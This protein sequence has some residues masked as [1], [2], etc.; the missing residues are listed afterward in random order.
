MKA[1]KSA[2]AA[3]DA[4]VATNTDSIIATNDKLNTEVARLDDVKADKDYIDDKVIGLEVT[5][6]RLDAAIKSSNTQIASMD[7]RFTAINNTQNLQIDRNT[8]SINELGYR[9]D[10]VEDKLNAGIANA[11]AF[12][13]L[14]SPPIPGRNMFTFGSGYHQGEAAI[15]LGFAGSRD[16]GVVSYKLGGSWSKEGGTSIGI[17]GGYIFD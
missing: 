13:S 3:T 1:D 10:K 5:D 14:P 7:D 16:D 12:A 17:G 15:A 4:N 2:L 6:E 11:I 8:Q 9:I